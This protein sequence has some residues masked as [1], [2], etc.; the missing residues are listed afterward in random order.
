MDKF[1][2]SKLFVNIVSFRCVRL[3]INKGVASFNGG[4]AAIFCI[5]HGG[6]QIFGQYCLG[7]YF[8]L[9]LQLTIVSL[10]QHYSYANKFELTAEVTGYETIDKCQCGFVLLNATKKVFVDDIVVLSGCGWH[11][12]IQS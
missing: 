7:T 10:G 1:E 8:F 4:L 3:V 9:T 5:S 6:L 12:D 2:K 11:N